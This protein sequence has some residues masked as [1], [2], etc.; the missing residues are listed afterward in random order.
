MSE[1]SRLL[2]A[3]AVRQQ[4]L[5]VELEE[6]LSLRS[7]AGVASASLA[8]GLHNATATSTQDRERSRR[9]SAECSCHPQGKGCLSVSSK[10]GGPMWLWEGWFGCS[11]LTQNFALRTAKLFLA[12]T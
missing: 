5:L 8:A 12:F 6:A 10:Q 9:S 3:S 1:V 2:K 11:V 7:C 4:R